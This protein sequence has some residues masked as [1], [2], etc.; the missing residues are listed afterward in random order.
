MTCFDMEKQVCRTRRN[1]SAIHCLYG[2]RCAKKAMTFFARSCLENIAPKVQ[3][4]T[5][6]QD[7]STKSAP[8]IAHGRCAV[9][10]LFSQFWDVES[11]DDN[12]AINPQC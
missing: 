8:T 10:Q 11:C 3:R 2:G 4:L 7:D 6:L 12:A 9:K 1:N 5:M